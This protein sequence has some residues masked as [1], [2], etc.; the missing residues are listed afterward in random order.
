MTLEGPEHVSS[1]PVKIHGPAEFS[2][3]GKRRFKENTQIHTSNDIRRLRTTDG[4]LR[5]YGDD[6]GG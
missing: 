6:S 2:Q 5:A 1:P 3:K 4:I